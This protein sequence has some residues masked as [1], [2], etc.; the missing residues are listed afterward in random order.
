MAVKI[1]LSKINSKLEKKICKDLCL[2]PTPSNPK[3][4]AKSLLCFKHSEDGR[5]TNVPFTYG[6][7]LRFENPEHPSLNLEFTGTLRV[8]EKSDEEGGIDQ[9]EVIEEAKAM[10]DTHDTVSLFLCTGYGKT[11]ISALLTCYVNKKTLFI[12]YCKSTIKSTLAVFARDTNAKV[13]LVGGPKRGNVSPEDADVLV[14]MYT[15]THKVPQAVLDEIGLVVADECHRLCNASGIKAL[16]ATTPSKVI[17][18]TATPKRK[19]DGMDKVIKLIA[20]EHNIVRRTN[21][22]VKVVGIDTGIYSPIMFNAAGDID[23]QA[24]E[25]IP[26]L[27]KKRIKLI[28]Q[29][30]KNEESRT[31]LVLTKNVDPA[32]KLEKALGSMGVAC[33]T[34]MGNDKSVVDRRVIIGTLG[35]IGIGFDK[36][37]ACDEFT[38]NEFDMVILAQSIKDPSTL[39]QAFG[40][41][42]RGSECLV[43]HIIDNNNIFKK[44]WREA[45]ETYEETC[46]KLEIFETE[47]QITRSRD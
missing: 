29:L 12:L 35:K 25:E 34:Y 28:A 16:L 38:G 11:V 8:S 39:T 18:L 23:Y 6:K 22:T 2:I 44:H 20:G 4:T 19:R 7:E 21:C 24:T 17:V 47:S 46:P 41:G 5:T 36:A 27:N 1:D 43:I 31:I 32:L 37:N 33:S 13:C 40:R 45:K 3:Y 42:L 26:I 14:C 15:R 10:L 9:A 30:C